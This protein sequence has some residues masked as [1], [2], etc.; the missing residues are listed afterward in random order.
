MEGNSTMP[1]WTHYD[2][3]QALNQGWGLFENADHGLRIERNDKSPRFAHDAAAQAYV[4]AAAAHGVAL[5]V[6]EVFALQS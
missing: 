3:K 1:H 2:Q 6:N 5:A 4:G